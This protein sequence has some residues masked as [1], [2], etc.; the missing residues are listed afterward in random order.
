MYRQVAKRKL[1]VGGNGGNIVICVRGVGSLG[2]PRAQWEELKMMGDR[3]IAEYPEATS[4]DDI[5]EVKS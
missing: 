5:P 2:V 1:T 3:F 4:T